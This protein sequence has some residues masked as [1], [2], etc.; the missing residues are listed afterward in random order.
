MWQTKDLQEGIFVS[1]AMVRLSRRFSGSV[2]RKGLAGVL[3]EAAAGESG[4][5]MRKGWRPV[6][7]CERYHRIRIFS[8]GK[9]IFFA[10]SGKRS[11]T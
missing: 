6:V 4:R 8:S 5:G 3:G 10:E 11:K 1:V 7:T 2:A 9:C